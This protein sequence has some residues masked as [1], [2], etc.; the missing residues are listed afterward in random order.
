M[1]G[2]IWVDSRPGVGSTFH[3]TARLG[4]P[5]AEQIEAAR[6][7]GAGPSQ[8]PEGAASLRILLAEDNRV[9]QV[10]AVRLLEK[11]GHRVVVVANGREAVETW[12]AQPFDAILMDVQMPEMNGLEA[13]RLIRRIEKDSGRHVPVI[14]MTAH[15]MKG[16]RQRCL[17]AGMDEYISKP[18]KPGELYVLLQRLLCVEPADESAPPAPPDGAAEDGGPVDLHAALDG[19][20]G[21]VEILREAVA[22]FL[23]DVPAKLAE[24]EAAVRGGQAEDVHRLSHALK[25][26]ASAIGAGRAGELAARLEQIGRDADLEQARDVLQRLHAEIRQVAAFLKRPDW[27]LALRAAR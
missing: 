24:L 13:T 2:R 18:I 11:R 12:K 16:D 9:N 23:E 21:Q 6:Q 15:A 19:M 27:H 26:A 22:V 4:L 20:A 5:S 14:A 25:G 10:L 17:D 1:G 7:A 8:A 3:F